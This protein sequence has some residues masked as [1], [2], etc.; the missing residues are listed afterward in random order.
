MSNQYQPHAFRFANGT[1]TASMAQHDVT[2][3]RR[4]GSQSSRNT[5]NEAHEARQQRSLAKIDVQ[6]PPRKV[7]SMRPPV[8]SVAILSPLPVPSIDSILI[9]TTPPSPTASSIYSA[10]DEG[11]SPPTSI[12]ST[13]LTPTNPTKQSYADRVKASLTNT[14]EV[15]GKQDADANNLE[16]ACLK[17]L[18]SPEI[19]EAV[20]ATPEKSA[21]PPPTSDK[22]PLDIR[23]SRLFRS[24]CVCDINL[25]GLPIQSFSRMFTANPRH[26]KVGRCRFLNF[27]ADADI[28]RTGCSLYSR[29]EPH[30]LTYVLDY[31]MPMINRQSGSREY[32][33]AAQLD[34]T[35]VVRDLALNV[36]G[37]DSHE[38]E[39]HLS[40]VGSIDWLSIARE[41]A[42]EETSGASAS[43]SQTE[44]RDAMAAKSSSAEVTPEKLEE[45]SQSLL[46]LRHL[47][48]YAFMLSV[49]AYSGSW[50]MCWVSQALWDRSR[51]DIEVGLRD[52]GPEVLERLGME[53]IGAA[54]A[55]ERVDG[56]ILT[57]DSWFAK[58]EAGIVPFAMKVRWG[59]EG[60]EK[61]MYAVPTFRP[62]DRDNHRWVC[63][64]TEKKVGCVWKL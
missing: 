57:R 56:C 26:L 36:L 18:Q 62:D 25:S 52:S 38:V 30:S 54:Q 3:Q 58:R 11:C 42:L 39:K 45:F 14:S 63:F 33:L 1:S 51:E 21:I 43:E 23:Y 41:Y 35:E 27:P 24:L 20:S 55:D 31:V 2:P 12:D 61:W 7:L 64:L 6:Q 46:D 32:L 53:L 37:R 17:L 49:S 4:D 50:Q 15:T 29:R 22:D 48:Q 34:I 60:V 9:P 8:D 40:K 59:V 13:A 19:V 28:G 16:T 47:H 5:R 10:R 44:H